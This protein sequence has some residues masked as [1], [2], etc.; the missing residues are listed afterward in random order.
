M[1]TNYFFLNF[2]TTIVNSTDA[3]CVRRRIV[4]QVKLKQVIAKFCLRNN[5]CVKHEEEKN[6]YKTRLDLLVQLRI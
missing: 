1:K 2:R 6:N 3:N 4:R 5:T